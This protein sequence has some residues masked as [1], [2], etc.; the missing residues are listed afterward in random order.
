M[1]ITIKDV[2]KK[3]GVATSTV[4]RTIQDHSSISEKTKKKVR[5]VMKELGYQPNLAARGLVNKNMRTIG[6]ILPVSDGSVFKNPFFL[7]MIRGISKACNEKK[8]MVALAS[9]TTEEELLESIQ[10]MAKGGRADGFIVLYSKKKDRV[11]DYLHREKLFYAMIG[12]PYEYENEIVYVDNDNQLAG[13]DATDYL[14]ALKHEKIAYIDKKFDQM[15]SKERL[16]GYKQALML[17]KIEMNPKY[18][19][20]GQ[21]KNNGLEEQVRK[22]F[23]S[24]NPPTAIV[25]G[26]DLIAMELIY[27][28][29]EINLSIPEDVSI[30]SFNNSIFTEMVQPTLTSIDLHVT[31][32]SEQVVEKLVDFIEGKQTL[33]IKV[34]LPHEIIE[35]KSC[36]WQTGEA[37]T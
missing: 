15:M 32:L 2:A 12:K 6:V 37:R 17:A 19:I 31:Y 30:I 21:T 22:L 18:I 28:L 14:L 3:A 33:A 8:Y 25:A 24:E 29:K 34:I 13:K 35:R 11:I 27:L 23:S 7:E 36:N 4:S 10:T 16:A 26:D 1:A 5:S 9:G 20:Q